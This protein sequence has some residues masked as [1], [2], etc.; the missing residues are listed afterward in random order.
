MSCL[1]DCAALEH[2]HLVFDEWPYCNI[3]CVGAIKTLRTLYLEPDSEA[4]LEYE[5]LYK[6]GPHI[7]ILRLLGG[8]ASR[9]FVE[10]PDW[11]DFLPTLFRTVSNLECFETTQDARALVH[12]AS[13]HSQQQELG[14]LCDGLTM[15]KI[16]HLYVVVDKR[17][18]A[19]RGVLR[20]KDNVGLL[21]STGSMRHGTL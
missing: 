7:R 20:R 17:S 12:A 21:H 6:L 16:W 9:S 1:Q 8:A 15:W 19:L 14:E 4:S 2:L 18:T 11:K 5:T 10:V 3:T 13:S